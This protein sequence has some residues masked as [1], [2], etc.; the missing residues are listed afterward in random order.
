ML[1]FIIIEVAGN[2]FGFEKLQFCIIVYCF[3]VEGKIS[4]KCIWNQVFVFQ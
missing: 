2:P 3:N 1:L 4:Q